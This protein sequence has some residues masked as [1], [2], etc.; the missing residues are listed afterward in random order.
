M[1]TSVIDH[2]IPDDARNDPGHPIPNLNVI[3]VAGYKKDGGADL[4]VVIASPLAADAASQS[5]LLDK[6]EGYLG[7]VRSDEFLADAGVPA[8]PEN[9]TIT[10]LL[11][12]DCAVQV[13]EVLG[14]CQPWVHQNG[15]S[16]VV[17]DL[18]DEELGCD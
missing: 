6:L 11:H 15:A 3:D 12:P 13:R 16:L 18:T 8:S 5:R 1:N 10:V 9:T 14:R 2:P 7:Y 17:R 4:C